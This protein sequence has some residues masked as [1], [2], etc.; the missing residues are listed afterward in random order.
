LELTMRPL[1]NDQRRETINTRQRYMAFREAK[2]RL[3][4]Y[5]G[6]MVWSATK[7][8]DYLLHSSYADARGRRTQ[9]SLGP[10]S[11]ATEQIKL[12]FE[13]GRS[14]A[15]RRLKAAKATLDRQG[16]L[17]RALGLGRVPLTSARIIRALDEIGVLGKGLRIVGTN[18]LYAYE[19]ASGVFVDP[20]IT[21]TEDIDLLFDARRELRFVAS[22]DLG[23]DGLMGLL[24]RIDPSFARSRE[25]FRAVNDEGF[26]VDLI[27]PAAIPPWKQVRD[28]LIGAADDLSAVA[29]DGLEWLEN[30]P[31]FEAVAI[32]ER[33]MPLRIVAVDPRVFAAHKFWLS[34]PPGRD[35]LKRDRDKAQAEA[36]GQLVA[37]HLTHLSIASKELAALPR[38]IVETAR[39]LFRVNGETR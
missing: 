34:G 3:E 2:Q 39:P 22:R 14:T 29:I 20:D 13:T 1:D 30:A 26:L 4:G 36:V 35:P 16:A 7:G 28:S 18:A 32:D 38:A 19:A 15:R 25:T 9:K 6:S 11:P 24:R 5:R 21:S 17:N 33:G 12:D 37:R 23:E 27:M 10:R 31:P 8:T